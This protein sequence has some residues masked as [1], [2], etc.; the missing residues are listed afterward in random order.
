[1]A[2][3]AAYFQLFAFIGF[4]CSIISWPFFG[5]TVAWRMGLTSLV[6]ILLFAM[7]Y[8]GLKNLLKKL[9]P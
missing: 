6:C 9:Q 7:V 5:W 1:M 3:I 4:V 8:N 2:L